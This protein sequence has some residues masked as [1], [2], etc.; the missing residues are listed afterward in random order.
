MQEHRTGAANDRAEAIQSPYRSAR[1]IVVIVQKRNTNFYG[2][3]WKTRTGCSESPPRA[4]T[5][6]TYAA[7]P[8]GSSSEERLHRG[9]RGHERLPEPATR[10]FLLPTR[11]KVALALTTRHRHGSRGNQY[12]REAGVVEMTVPPAFRTARDW[13]RAPRARRRASVWLRPR[14][15]AGFGERDMCS[16]R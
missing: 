6:A 11:K 12:Y 1:N 9:E 8:R 2:R 3:S 15:S 7:S 14:R 16:A 5:A 4:R 13:S 10:P